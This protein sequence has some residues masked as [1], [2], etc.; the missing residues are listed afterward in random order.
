MFIHEN[1]QG[2]GIAKLLLKE[3]ERY[4]VENNI[5]RITSEVSL[6]ARPFFER[7]GYVVEV[8][9]KYKANQLSLTNFVMAKVC[10]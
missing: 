8:E 6:T 5:S 3:V 7:H 2:R 4:A 10:L 1:F 9:Q